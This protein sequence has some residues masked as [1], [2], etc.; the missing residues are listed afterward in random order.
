MRTFE[1]FRSLF[2]CFFSRFARFLKKILDFSRFSWIFDTCICL[3]FWNHKKII[4]CENS[5]GELVP[6]VRFTNPFQQSVST[7]LFNNMFHQ[8]YSKVRPTNKSSK[9]ELQFICLQ[10]LTFIEIDG[11]WNEMAVVSLHGTA[12]AMV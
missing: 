12:W 5:I 3:T 6:V 11:H 1:N 7:V 8:I 4:C 9:F 10:Y 2:C